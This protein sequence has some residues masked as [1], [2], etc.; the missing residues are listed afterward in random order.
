MLSIDITQAAVQIAGSDAL[1]FIHFGKAFMG[2]QHGTSVATGHLE[3]GCRE[4]I[5]LGL[6]HHLVDTA[7]PLFTDV[8]AAHKRSQCLITTLRRR[9]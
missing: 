5:K 9:I 3:D 2:K 8:D 4:L 1:L 7:A 6:K